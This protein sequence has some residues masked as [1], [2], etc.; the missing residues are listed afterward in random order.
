MTV[1]TDTGEIVDET[2][3]QTFHALPFP[4]FI[5]EIIEAGGLLKSL[6]ARGL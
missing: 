2:T 5:T 3:G 4:P 6:K 1:D